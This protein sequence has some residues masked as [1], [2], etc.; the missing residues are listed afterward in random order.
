MRYHLLLADADN[1]LFDFSRAERAAL[2]RTLTRY[3]LPADEATVARYSAINDRHWKALERGETTKARVRVE[4]FVDFLR[5]VGR[6]ELSAEEVSLLFVESLSRQRF[7]M[8]GALDFCR[9]V[10]AAMPIYLVTNGIARVQRA[11]FG[12]SELSPYLSGLIISEEVGAAKPDPRMLTVAMARAGVTDPRRAALLGDSLTADIAA[13]ARA[14]VDS[15]WFTP[16]RRVAPQGG[17]TYAVSTL[18]EAA[19]LLLAPVDIF[20]RDCV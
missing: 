15:L 11:R 12:D 19:E 6:A 4:R 9:R 5:E 18:G 3:G 14:G 10:S 20:P 1:T 16:G 7:L 13:A 17:A 2:E 8:P